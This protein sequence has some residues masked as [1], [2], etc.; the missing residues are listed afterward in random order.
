MRK[1][2]KSK[3]ATVTCTFTGCQKTQQARPSRITKC[4]GYAC[5]A[6]H[7]P[8]NDGSTAP[9][10]GFVRETVLNAAGGFWG[11]RDAPLPPGG[12][13]SLDRAGR[14]AL[15]GLAQTIPAARVHAVVS[16]LI[17]PVASRRTLHILHVN[18]MSTGIESDDESGSLH[19]ELPNVAAALCVLLGSNQQVG[20]ILRTFTDETVR[21]PG[22]RIPLPVKEVRGWLLADGHLQ[23]LT[24]SEVADAYRT[25][26]DPDPS[27]GMTL[28]RVDYDVRFHDAWHVELPA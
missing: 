3:L 24:A 10:P 9:P 16:A 2:T 17:E 13:A 15:F 19:I 28:R 8:H 11:W 1:R 27:R 7:L 14:L 6:E 25:G 21:L 5:C 12:H 26:P 22:R 18:E 20:V 4:D 23:P